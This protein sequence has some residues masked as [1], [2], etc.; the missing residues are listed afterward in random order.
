MTWRETVVLSA[1]VNSGLGM[2]DGSLV[3]PKCATVLDRGGSELRCSGCEAIYPV[4]DGIPIFTERDEYWCNVDRETM[5]R[6]IADAV[7]SKDWLSA[8]ERH[9]AYCAPHIVPFYRADAQFLLPIDSE[10]RVLDAGSMWG[11]ITV[12][13][14]QYCK[15]V[16]AVDKTWETLR[17]L[18]V[19]AEQLCLKNITPIVSGIHRLP[20]PDDHFD[21]IVLNGVLEWLGT[22]QDM[23]LE[24]HWDAKQ[25][26]YH[27]HEKTPG[28]MQLEGLR[29]LHRVL[30]QDGAIYVASE[31]RIGLQYYFGY[32]DDHVN[33][34]F[35]GV[36]PRSFANFLTKKIR[37]TEYRTYT[38]SPKRL[39]ELVQRAGF[40]NGKLYS[41]YPHYNTLSRLT[42]FSLFDRLGRL[43]RE[44]DVPFSVSGRA[45]VYAFSQVWKLLPRAL[46]KQ[47]S[48]SL[49]L[50]ATKDAVALKPARL[51]AMLAKAGLLEEGASEKNEV[52]VVNSRFGNGNPTNYLVYDRANAKPR[53]FCKIARQREDQTLQEEWEM[54]AYARRRMEGSARESS[55]PRSVYAG[56]VDGVP[57]QVTEFIEG[58]RAG[59]RTIDALRHIDR[60]T[61]E[62]P[63]ALRWGADRIKGFAR[64]CWLRSI[65]S[66]VLE[67]VDWLA[68]FQA[69]TKIRVLDLGRDGP[70]WL[71][72][73]WALIEANGIDVSGF[74]NSRTALSERL[75]SL[76]GHEVP[77]CMQHGDFDVCNLYAAR[78]RLVILDFEH[79]VKE[80]LATFDLAN[81]IFNP[82]LLE[83][84][85][86]RRK[87]TIP[88]YA[89]STSWAPY[90]RSW[91]RRYAE[92]SG[93]SPEAL[94]LLPVLGVIEQNAKR[95]PS[96][97]NP[98]DYPMFGSDSLRD[99]HD[100]HLDL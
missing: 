99:M 12:P 63:P 41:A 62:S 77:V 58:R 73:Q 97:R 83:W 50:I 28:Q 69:A 78:D 87:L 52:A 18:D 13:L 17:F 5:H 88:D 61:A 67:A 56:I 27:R 94:S 82:L 30:K 96:H 8:V 79:A 98:S 76:R 22:E 84:Q 32:P 47:V 34:R 24:K 54:M 49:S 9:I 14:A 1:V 60:F 44:G 4:K 2:G 33:V 15:E 37:N 51:L 92:R 55:I 40:K 66:A 38:Y 80:G 85:D 3:C 29:E 26:G 31:N 7:S 36:L 57:I 70:E 39:F 43:P 59:N 81:L 68:D 19:R 20:F 71:E 74:E 65:D 100:W 42:P 75:R 10:S 93:M 21:C 72:R 86:G 53:Y 11:G 95:Y 90:F 16:Y 64:D 89:A 6:V 23:V 35:A 48:P 45:K 91:V 25:A 46:G